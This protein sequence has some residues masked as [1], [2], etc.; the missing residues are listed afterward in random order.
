MG[1]PGTLGKLE[2]TSM[3]SGSQWLGES[4]FALFSMR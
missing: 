2:G 1:Y 4:I 3:R